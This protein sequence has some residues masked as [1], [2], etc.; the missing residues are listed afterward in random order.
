MREDDALGLLDE[1]DDLEVELLAGLS[2]CAIGLHEVLRSGKALTAFVERDDGTLVHHLG[3]L[4][5]VDAAGSVDGLVGIPRIVLELLVAKAQ[6]TVLLVDFEHNNID[7][8]TLLSE[9]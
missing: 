5:G 2:L 7:V 4:T 6:T 3:N 9:L 8:S 1:L